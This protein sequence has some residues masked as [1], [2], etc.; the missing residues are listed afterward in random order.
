[1]SPAASDALAKLFAAF[2]R[3]PVPPERVFV[4]AESLADVPEPLLIEACEH[5]RLTRE[6]LPPIAVIRRHIAERALQLPSSTEAA[7]QIAGWSR[8]DYDGTLH[9]LVIRARRSVGDS[10]AW[11]QTT[12]PE[13][14]MRDALAAYELLREQAIV[15]ATTGDLGQTGRQIGPATVR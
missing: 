4:Y 13:R 1:M 11:R 8:G 7:E 6:W 9:P 3:E 12:R 15:E 5:L 10:W 14:M 2:A